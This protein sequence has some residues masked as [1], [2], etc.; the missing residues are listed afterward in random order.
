V[1]TA[2]SGLPA[3]S[4]TALVD[5]LTFSPAISSKTPMP[6]PFLALGSERLCVPYLFLA[7]NNFERN[8]LKLINRHPNLLR[9]SNA[10]NKA[11]E[12]LALQQ[13][14]L[15]FPVPPFATKSQVLL[16]ATEADLVIYEGASGWALI[17]QHKWLIGP[18]TASESASNDD[19]L[20]KGVRQAL[21]AREHWRNNPNHLHREL[22]LHAHQTIT[23]IEALVIC[24]GA[25]P[26][27]FF[28]AEVPVLTESAFRSLLN[29]LSGL[30]TLWGRIVS[31]PDLNTA[32][33]RTEDVTYLVELAGYE[34]AMQGLE[35]AD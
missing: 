10:V 19:E 27:G 26:T 24:R 28:R 6:Q 21:I 25:E 9:Y 15:L 31:R 3:S 23:N 5:W 34:F 11:K 29:P 32:A 7:A 1:L 20:S 4:T 18:D 17:L 2:V 14:S 33:S 30:P 35:M 22:G 12:P 13:L 16:P 8:L